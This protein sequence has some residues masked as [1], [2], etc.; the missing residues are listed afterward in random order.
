LRVEEEPKGKRVERR[1]YPKGGPTS[2]KKGDLDHGALWG[3]GIDGPGSA[4]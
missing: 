4:G 1:Q 2:L 3:G